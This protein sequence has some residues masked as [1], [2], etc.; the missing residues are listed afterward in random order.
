MTY[1]KPSS[2]DAIYTPKVCAWLIRKNTKRASTCTKI[3]YK[4]YEI[5]ICMDDCNGMADV[6]GRSDVLVFDAND[7]DV[8]VDFLGEGTIPATAEALKQI[9]SIIDTRIG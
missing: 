3:P 2:P 9:F 1:T 5:S 6:L 4:G 7:N 8:T